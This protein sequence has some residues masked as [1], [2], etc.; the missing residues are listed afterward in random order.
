M[1]KATATLASHLNNTSTSAVGAG[2]DE[3]EWTSD[4]DF[5]NA[6]SEK[7]QRWGKQ[8]TID[9]KTEASQKEM[10]DLR[11]TVVSQHETQIKNE[12][13]S[14]NGAHVKESYG[15]LKSK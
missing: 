15:A 6:V 5:V 3:E 8:K 13:E 1:W 12:W 4:P 11:A 2:G 7:D 10:A 9:D 14:R